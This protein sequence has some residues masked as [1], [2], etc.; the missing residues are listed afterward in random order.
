MTAS[1]GF[2]TS[3]ALLWSLVLLQGLVLLGAVRKIY[4]LQR[5]GASFDRADEMRG[6][7]GEK[8]PSF[9]GPLLG[10][11]TLSSRELRGSGYALAF[12]SPD[13]ASCSVSLNELRALEL[14][15]H[16]RVIV[17]CKSTKANCR[18]LVD[19]HQ[20]TLPVIVDQ[21]NTLSES[22]DVSTV[23]SAVVV[24]EDG[25]IRTTGTPLREED[26]D[27]LIQGDQ[28]TAQTQ[29]ATVNPALPAS[30]S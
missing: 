8:V 22:L 26:L 29:L 30:D 6:L 21:D 20:I 11:G 3:Y 27:A 19:R 7:R 18:E 5:F 28:D 15:A 9:K 10:G 14:K 17:V 23:P 4:L 16:G 12:V 1:A 13:C 24:A 25:R 2:V